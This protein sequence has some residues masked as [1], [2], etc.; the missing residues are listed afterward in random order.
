M[1]SRQ[2]NY[3]FSNLPLKYTYTRGSLRRNIR[4]KY[5]KNHYYESQRMVMYLLPYKI[6][7]DILFKKIKMIKLPTIKIKI[8]RGRP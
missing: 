2:L 5:C 7:I 1:K 6:Y 4:T 8:S 3:I